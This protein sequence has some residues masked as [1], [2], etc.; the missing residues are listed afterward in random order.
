MDD[1]VI[2]VRQ[3]GNYPQLQ[4]IGAYDL[5]LVQQGGIG[6]PYAC[7]TQDGLLGQVFERMNVGILPSPNN[8]GVLA[9]CLS[10][11]LGQRQG[12]NWYVDQLG[13]QS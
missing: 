12:F 8:K 11:P 9:S 13:V 7:V 4:F 1:F 6:G 3:I 5:V 10:T 2:N